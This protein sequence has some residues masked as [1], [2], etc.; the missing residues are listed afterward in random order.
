M[1]RRLRAW[2]EAPAGRR[3]VWSVVY[4]APGGPGR[5]RIAVQGEVDAGRLLPIVRAAL[6][7]GYDPF[8]VAVEEQEPPPL[9]EMAHAWL[10]DL[11]RARR[12]ATVRRHKHTLAMFLDYLCARRGVGEAELRGSDV[13]TEAMRGY[14]TWL[15]TPGTGA[16]PRSKPR[17]LATCRKAMETVQLFSRW[18]SKDER[19]RDFIHE[20]AEIPLPPRRPPRQ[21]APTWD[22]MAAVVLALRTEWMQRAAVLMYFTGLRVGLQVMQLRWATDVDL[23]A[24]VIRIQRPELCKTENEAGLQRVLPLAPQLRRILTAWEARDGG[25]EAVRGRYVVRRAPVVALEEAGTRVFRG[26]DMRRAWERALGGVPAGCSN[27]SHAFRHGFAHGLLAAGVPAEVVSYIL[28]HRAQSLALSTY[29][30]AARR[31]ADAVLAAFQ[32]I[33]EV[34]AFETDLRD[35]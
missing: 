26:R 35:A 34:P 33:P 13:S 27:P 32:Q 9:L 3:R 14:W 21:Y 24:G 17:A 2:V 10:D 12:P 8:P 30:D 1:S 23:V 11:E 4:E 18:A 20:P 16:T 6:Q 7:G 28:G 29:D 22:E 15:A 25:P 31:H 5:R 19:F